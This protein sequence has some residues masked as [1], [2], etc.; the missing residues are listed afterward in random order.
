MST[1]IDDWLAR[2]SIPFSPD[3][4]DSLNAAVDR[5]IGLLDPAVQVLGLGEP[6]HGVDDFLLL[7]N[8]IFQR[9]AQSHGYTAFAIESSFPRGA[10]A[11][12]YVT[13]SAGAA[14]SFEEIAETGFSHGFGK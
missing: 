14:S 1:A 12:D 7:R 8:R 3:S 10:V 9:L 11:I 13:G 6:M 5:M 2:D 4:P